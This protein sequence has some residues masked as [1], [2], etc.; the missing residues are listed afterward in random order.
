[1]LIPVKC[2]SHHNASFFENGT[3]SQCENTAGGTSLPNYI[4]CPNRIAGRV[5]ILIEILPVQYG[6]NLFAFFTVDTECRL[7]HRMLKPFCIRFQENCI[8]WTDIAT[9]TATS[10]GCFRQLRRRN[11]I[12]LYHFF[13]PTVIVSVSACGNSKYFSQKERCISCLPFSA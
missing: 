3:G 4:F 11:Q 12:V 10:T 8:L 13:V 9:S 7:N 5:G 2:S 1:M 6:T